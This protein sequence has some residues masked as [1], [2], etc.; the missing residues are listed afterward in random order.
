MDESEKIHIK[1]KSSNAEKSA[2]PLLEVHCGSI[3][4]NANF[5]NC[6]LATP[7]LLVPMHTRDSNVTNRP[8][9]PLTW[10]FRRLVHVGVAL[11]SSV[12]QFRNLVPCAGQFRFWYLILDSFDVGA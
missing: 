8:R 3:L 11:V 7:H 12:G 5:L 2:L 1:I 6:N 9:N 10:T 4:K